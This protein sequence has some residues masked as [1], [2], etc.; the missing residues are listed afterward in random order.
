MSGEKMAG[1]DVQGLSGVTVA[2][3]GGTALRGA[4]ASHVCRR[5]Q[6]VK[7]GSWEGRAYSSAEN[8]CVWQ[9]SGEWSSHRDVCQ[10][11]SGTAVGQ[12]VRGRAV[13]G[14]RLEKRTS[15]GSM[16]LLL[17]QIQ[18]IV[19]GGCLKGVAMMDSEIRGEK[20]PGPSLNHGDKECGSWQRHRL[21]SDI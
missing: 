19:C 11:T 10:R 16:S 9:R 2:G 4:S 1:T 18:G 21:C 14:V 17:F 7:N 8:L 20:A 3:R 5:H 6:T 12:H 15:R 13:A